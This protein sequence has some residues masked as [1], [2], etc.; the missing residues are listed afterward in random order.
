L[1]CV[2]T[3]QGQTKDVPVKQGVAVMKGLRGED[4]VDLENDS[5]DVVVAGQWYDPASRAAVRSFTN[6]DVETTTALK[7]GP[8]GFVVAMFLKGSEKEFVTE[9]TNDM[10]DE[11][12]PAVPPESLAR[13]RI[14]TKTTIA[15][16]TR[17]SG[18]PEV[19]LVEA[20]LTGAA[21][22]AIKKRVYSYGYHLVETYCERRSMTKETLSCVSLGLDLK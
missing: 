4:V 17:V 8:D 9:L 18:R 7:R 20:G 22:S 12:H 6:G 14:R 11:D 19:Q 16:L 5:E 1:C 13:R 3:H 15:P 2:L 10:L 21:L